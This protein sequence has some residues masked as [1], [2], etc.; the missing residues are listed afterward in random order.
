MRILV[1]SVFKR[2]GGFSLPEVAT[3]VAIT[4]TLAAV[5]TPVA[6]D[7]VEKGRT[8]SAKQEVQAISDAINAF[9][10]DTGQWP[11]RTSKGNHK[12]THI[13]RSGRAEIPNVLG[14]SDSAA[15]HGS[16]PALG[17]TNWGTLGTTVDEFLNHLSLDNPL[18][19]STPG[20]GNG[21]GQGK[22]NRVYRDADVNW[23]GPYLPQIF[24]DPWGSHYLVFARAFTE[25]KVQG[26][27]IYAWVISA[28]PNKTLETDVTSPILNNNPVSG[29]SSTADDVGVLVFQARE[30]IPG[31]SNG[32]R[33]NG[34]G[35]NGT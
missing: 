31:V 21:N 12:G 34:N 29:K 17:N 8:A 7:Q 18:S 14:S 10:K 33:G 11:A 5:V 28:G 32:K 2:T 20:K 15:G 25:R 26:T 19:D 4:G 3:V 23:Q 9:F 16:D 35:N 13:L 22:A 24:N 30:N 6:I 27:S 1:G